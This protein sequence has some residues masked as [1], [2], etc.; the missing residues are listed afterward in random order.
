M[1]VK[2][3]LPLFHPDCNI[4]IFDSH[5]DDR[6]AQKQIADGSP[7]DL[8]ESFVANLEITLIDAGWQDEMC[9]DV[10]Y[11]DRATLHTQNE[12][13]KKSGILK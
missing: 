12:I 6:G 2:E 1:L 13:L 5:K 8:M 3:V 7:K 10:L 11:T 4:L 9:I